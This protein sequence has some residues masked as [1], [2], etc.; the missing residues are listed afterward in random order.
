MPNSDPWDRFA[1]PYLTLMSD[2]YSLHIVLV[3][4]Y[5][6]I[7]ANKFNRDYP[8]TTNFDTFVPVIS[9]RSHLNTD[10]SDLEILGCSHIGLHH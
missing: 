6:N 2:S 4:K 1:H 7:N 5:S 8:E 10:L 9:D 3:V